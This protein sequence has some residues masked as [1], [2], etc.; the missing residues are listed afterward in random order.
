[1]N[2]EIKFRAFVESE[3]IM[4][5]EL[6][7][8]EIACEFKLSKL[9]NG[10]YLFLQYTGLTDK[11]GKEIYEGDILKGRYSNWVVLGFGWCDGLYGLTL[12]TTIM[13]KLYLADK[14]FET[15]SEVIGNVFQNSELLK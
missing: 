13:D 15:S 7:V 8:F 9:N 3:K 11:N 14:S 12:K 10:K 1:M 2:R 5:P 6:S 4:L